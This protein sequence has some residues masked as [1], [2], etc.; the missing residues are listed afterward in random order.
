MSTDHQPPIPP[1][2][3]SPYQSPS[4]PSWFT[5]CEPQ[6]AL[7]IASPPV[8]L[9]KSSDTV[10]PCILSMINACL[11]SGSVQTAFKHAVVQPLLKKENLIP[12]FSLIS[13]P[14]SKL[15][16]LSKILEKIV[17]TQLQTFLINSNVHKKFQSGFKPHHSTATAESF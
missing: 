3:S 5:I 4:Y 10:K 7:P 11:L 12:L 8:F 1:I 17:L 16:F 6:L 2:N 15:T 14:I 9:K 13:G